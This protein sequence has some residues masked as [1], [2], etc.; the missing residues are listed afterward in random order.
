MSHLQ[1][2]GTYSE[3]VEALQTGAVDAVT[4]DD[5]DPRRFRRAGHPGQV[6]ARRQGLHRRELRHRPEEGRRRRH[7]GKINAAIAKMIADGSW[8]KALEDTF[9]PSGYTIP[10][11]PTPAS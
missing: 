7:R 4:T 3:C 2:Y 10:T 11:P 5:V 1:E 6:Q 9:G 8:K